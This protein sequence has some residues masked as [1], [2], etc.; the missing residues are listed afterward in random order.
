[1]HVLLPPSCHRHKLKGRRV[2]KRGRKGSRSAGAVALRLVLV[3]RIEPVK[4]KSRGIG[5]INLGR[6]GGETDKAR[7]KQAGTKKERAKTSSFFFFFGFWRR[8]IKTP[9]VDSVVTT[10]IFP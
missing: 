7:W 5:R 2:G 6:R 10:T 3:L 1:M 9:A 4:N 8:N